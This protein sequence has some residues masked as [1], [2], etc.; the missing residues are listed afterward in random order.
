MI[1]VDEDIDQP[2]SAL[3][4]SAFSVVHHPFAVLN[5]LALGT[6]S[7]PDSGHRLWNQPV[8]AFFYLPVATNLP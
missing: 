8:D 7:S 6:N 4:K 2:E 1:V 3:V 5:Q